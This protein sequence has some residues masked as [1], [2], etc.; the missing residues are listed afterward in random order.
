MTIP[1]NMMQ[2][3]PDGVWRSRNLGALHDLLLLACPPHPKSG[4]KSIPVLA[5]RLG[6]SKW[7]VYKWIKENKVPSDRVPA[8]VRLS[9]GRTDLAMFLPFVFVS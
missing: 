2:D 3:A 4:A 6:V 1:T 9:E 7:S 5:S 8:I